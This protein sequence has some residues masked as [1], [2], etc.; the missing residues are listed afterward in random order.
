MSKKVGPGTSR[1]HVHLFDEDWDFLS[2][3]FGR[4]NPKRVS[5]AEAIRTIVHA[6]VR[7][8]R[9]RAEAARDRA[10]PTPAP[11]EVETIHGI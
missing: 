8:M 7:N 2:T 1:R 4:D 5:V 10:E 6:S 11:T 3:V 9:A